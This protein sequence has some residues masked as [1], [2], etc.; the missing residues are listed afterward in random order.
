GL[1]WLLLWWWLYEPPER[2]PR[3][4][5]GELAYIRSD[6]QE[7]STPVSWLRLAALRQTWAFAIGK[8]LTDP[9]WWFYLYWVPKFLNEKHG[10]S[11]GQLGPP[12]IVIYMFADVGS[13]CGGWLSSRLLARGWGATPA[14]K[15]AMLVCALRRVPIVFASQ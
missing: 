14:R 13:I 6:P 9:V 11:L 12:L 2:H 3:V 5:P 10:L 7:A 1:L 8:F 4:T 15:T